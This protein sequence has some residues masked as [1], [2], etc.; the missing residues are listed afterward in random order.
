MAVVEKKLPAGD[1]RDA[2]LIPG[3]A[4]VPGG[5]NGNPLQCS[6]KCHGQRSLV[7]YNP[8]WGSQRVSYY[9]EPELTCTSKK[10]LAGCGLL[11]CDVSTF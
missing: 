9:L 1:T 6:G 11:N 4:R 8:F 2:G 7:G 5:G 3:M 10:K